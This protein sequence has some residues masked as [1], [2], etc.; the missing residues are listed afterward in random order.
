MTSGLLDRP[1]AEAELVV[2]VTESKRSDPL[3]PVTVVCP[4]G[5]AALYVRRVLASGEAGALR[6]IANLEALTTEQLV[7]KLGAPVLAR[8]GMRPCTPHVGLEA[9]RTEASARGGW[10]E[11][12]AAHPRA[13]FSLRRAIDELGHCPPAALGVISSR[14][15]QA[16]ELVGLMNALRRRLHSNGLADGLDLAMAALEA[17]PS[18]AEGTAEH[19]SVFTWQLATPSGTQVDLLRR[20]QARTLEGPGGLGGSESS[21][22]AAARGRLS[23]VLSCPDASE[24]ARSVVRR[25]IAAAESGIALW[26]QAVFHPPASAGYARLLRQQLSFSGI[27]ANGPSV[28][29]LDAT[30][31]SRALVGLIDLLTG[32]FARDDVIA[33]L[34]TAPLNAPLRGRGGLV[35]YVPA[36]TWDVISA[37][38]GVVKGPDQWQQRLRLYAED[39][40]GEASDAETLADFV[41]GLVQRAEPVSRSWSEHSK[42]AT[43]L[44]DDYLAP[45]SPS[46]LWPVEELAALEQ[47]RV[48]LG[49]LAQLDEVSDGTDRVR[50]GEALRSVLS[51]TDWEMD[52]AG[53]GGFGDGVFVA[54][55][56]MARGVG[57]EQVLVCGLADALVPGPGRVDPLL[58]DEVRMSD[59]SGTLR[60]RRGEQSEMHE[61]VVAAIRSGRTSRIATVPRSDPRSG[62]AHVTSRWLGDLCSSETSW[63]TIDSFA[64]ALASSGPALNGRD[65]E[66]R[67]MERWVSCGGDSAASPVVGS[68]AR[69]AAGF[70]AVRSRLGPH[71]TRFDGFV[72]PGRVSPFH[73]DRPVSATRFETYAHCPRR[74]LFER[75]LR[76]SRR[77]RPEELWRIEPP[78]RGSLVHAILEDYVSERVEGAA[79]SLDRLLEIAED[80]LDQAEAG[81]LVGKRLIWRM[82]RAAIV[83]ELRRFH[84]EEGELEPI[85]AELAFG[86][87]EEGLPA[88]AVTLEDGRT[89]NFR[90]A[91]DR[92]DRSASG[93]LVVSDYKTGRQAVLND[94][95]KDPVASGTLLQLPLYGMAARQRFGSDAPVHTRYW[96]LS[97]ERIAS[98]YSLMLTEAVEER[99][100]EVIGRIASGVE[101]G[102]FPGIPGA[103][104]YDGRFENCRH[105]DFDALCPPHR[106]REWSHKLADQKLV[107]VVRLVRDEADN[108]WSGTVVKGFV[109]PDLPVEPLPRR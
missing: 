33:W 47:L 55:F 4:S 44:L 71:F 13:L 43:G 77:V 85:A 68:D 38:A 100:R 21:G 90:G 78:E 16:S 96:L 103:A 36:T 106:D 6:G 99:F 28:T 82:D 34:N 54:P 88:V 64:A 95:M 102:C 24:E 2:A 60:T 65:L 97:S 86:D 12:F 75:V 91:A 101:E 30:A 25:V 79:R 17:A 19:G 67:T 83:R 11:R 76:A 107:S 41:G 108:S 93:T 26:E 73:P 53:A 37:E 72:G 9:L 22:S 3:A 48:A 98:R 35:R 56:A 45:R 84:T 5:Y 63:S 109:D 57:F 23:E 94:L 49:S 8:K 20:L 61:D 89:I 14:S 58:S 104:L 74:F 7:K 70:E 59:T 40:S 69:L 46:G 66:L 80:H 50:F 51:A 31:A 81:G 39:H 92:V 1:T 42:W 18:S 10:I 32:D 87:P 62:R 29:R 105:C 15:V 27:A 52:P